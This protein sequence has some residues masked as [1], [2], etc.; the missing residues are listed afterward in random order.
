VPQVPP[1]TRAPAAALGT[2][3]ALTAVVLL[4]PLAD[5]STDG[6][7]ANVVQ[8]LLA[9]TACVATATR[10]WRCAGR[11]R[12]TWV[13]ASVGCAGW[14]V[15]QAVWTWYELVA[16]REVPFPSPA[17]V[18]F[19]VFP[20]AMAVALWTYPA[21]G[22]WRQRRRLLDALTVTAAVA[23]M[24][25]PVLR[26]V[27]QAAGEDPLSLAVSL[28]YPA[29]DLVVLVLTVLMLTGAST[30]RWALG[31]LGAGL[32]AFALADGAFAYLTAS[33]SFASGHVVDL[34]W[35]LGFVLIT[36]AAAATSEQVAPPPADAD[37]AL[38]SAL[39]YVPVAV[40]AVAVAV[41]RLAGGELDAAERA[42]VAGAL[43]LLVA[44]QWV[45]LRENAQLAGELAQRERELRHQAFHDGLTGLAN[46]ALFLDRLDHALELHRSDLRPL[47]VLLCDLDDFKVV[48]DTQGHAAGDE[49]LVRVAERLR[50]ALRSADTLARLG[51]DE[52]AVLLE[53]GDEAESVAVRVVAA[54]DAPFFVAGRALGVRA[55]VGV[56]LVDAT[57]TT[58]GTDELLARADTAMYAAKRAGKG[59]L[60][61]YEDGMSL[62]EVEDHRLAEALRRAI[63][64]GEVDVVFQP[65]VATATGA[66]EGL[67]TLARWRWNGAPV[68]PQVFVPVAERHGL[69]AA[70]TDLVLDRALSELTN[71]DARLGHSRLR[72]SVNVAPQDLCG[73][74]LATRVRTRLSAHGVLADRLVLEVTESGL[75]TDV[76]AARATAEDLAAFGVRLALDDFGVGYSSL[77]HLHTIPLRILKIDRAFTAGLD[78]DANQVRFVRALLALAHDLGLDVVAEGVERPAQLA[79]LRDL[80]CEMVQGWL[81]ARP[82]PAAALLPLL[83]DGAH[84]PVA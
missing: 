7:L 5:E 45:T 15:G 58:P 9:A 50:G 22:G 35:M 57:A 20:A 73:G 46:R 8:L 79:L 69:V 77:A 80:G 40:A 72:I 32:G 54:L 12:L 76:A 36:L 24:S 42:L 10:A 78:V 30:D 64:Q 44:R 27:A 38:V 34:G 81:L 71:L 19:L 49:L 52:F 26:A 28:A 4:T 84:L 47:A 53:H 29:G 75:L 14:T 59:R 62:A 39:P 31:L 2:V 70:L 83:R 33:G 3:L 65:V 21:R 61:L 68:P 66:V 11:R 74:T 56:A 25:W 67:E 48:N 16:G 37:I 18:G 1:S 41:R 43:L 51:G 6:A 60:R 23:V 17:D 82:A 63:A 13:A 55:S